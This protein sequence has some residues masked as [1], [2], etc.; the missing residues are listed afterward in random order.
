MCLMYFIYNMN[1]LWLGWSRLGV[2]ELTG[3]W[4]LYPPVCYPSWTRGYWATFL[5]WKRLEQKR[6]QAHFM[7]FLTLFALYHIGQN[8]SYGCGHSQR[9]EKYTLS[10]IRLWQKY[11]YMY[12]AIMRWRSEEYCT[13]FE[14]DNLG[15]KFLQNENYFV[16]II[17][18][19]QLLS[20]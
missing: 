6:T 2:A 10:T 18:D 8:K 11:V 1:C 15:E 4:R 17:K 3:S 16:G 19:P 20:S 5:S 9:V 7:P 13:V 12:D 14:A